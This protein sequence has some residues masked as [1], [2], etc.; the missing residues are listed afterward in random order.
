[1]QPFI[2]DQPYY[3]HTNSQYANYLN[4]NK[5]FIKKIGYSA[6][7]IDWHGNNSPKFS[8]PPTKKLTDEELLELYNPSKA[9]S[10]PIK[11]IPNN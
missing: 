11:L 7:E 4:H 8:R 3:Q 6:D 1:M 2:S 5:K 10:K 9:D